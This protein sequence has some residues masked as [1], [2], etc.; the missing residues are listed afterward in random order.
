MDTVTISEKYQMVIPKAVRKKWKIKP[1][2]KVRLIVYGNVLEVVPVRSIKEAR[3]FLKG[4]SSS[5]E[6][7]EED[8]V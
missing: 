7:E 3:G 5:V 1:G 6:R 2:Q 8:R 4:M